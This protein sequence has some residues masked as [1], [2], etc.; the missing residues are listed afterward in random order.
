[1]DWTATIL[2]A[3]KA[4]AEKHFA[5]DGIDLM[6]FLAGKKNNLPRQLFWRVTQRM[7]QHALREGDWKYLKDE[8]GEYLFNLRDDPS[9]K[10]DLK[11]ND[12][13]LFTR[14]KMTYA[15]WEKT[16]LPPVPLQ[17]SERGK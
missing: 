7:Q 5:L 4:K 13:T 14:L 15:N 3:A 12:S 1:M 8:K 16:V 2:A 17:T 9:E 6:P 10:K 11:A